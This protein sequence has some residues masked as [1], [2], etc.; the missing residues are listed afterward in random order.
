MAALLVDDLR[1]DGSF[2]N[3]A[4]QMRNGLELFMQGANH[5]GLWRSPYSARSALSVAGVLG[6]PAARRSPEGG[7]PRD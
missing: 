1:Y 7:P 6:Y 4:T 2:A 5:G 3:P